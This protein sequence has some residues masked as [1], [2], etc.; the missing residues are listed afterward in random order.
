M[1]VRWKIPGR[2][3]LSFVSTS[4]EVSGAVRVHTER[5]LARQAV[6]LI[7]AGAARSRHCAL[8]AAAGAGDFLVAL[9]TAATVEFISAAAGEHHVRVAV[10]EAGHHHKALGV[11]LLAGWRNFAL[12]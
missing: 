8:D 12:V 5:A 2:L 4:S 10:D 9:A 1:Y 6:K 7:R 11:Y 3:C